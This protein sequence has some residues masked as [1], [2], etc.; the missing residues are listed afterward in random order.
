[1]FIFGLRLILALFLSG[2]QLAHGLTNPQ[3]EPNSG[4]L[5]VETKLGSIYPTYATF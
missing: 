5:L 2:Y 4:S 1:M 3:I